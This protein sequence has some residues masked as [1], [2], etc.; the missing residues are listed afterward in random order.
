[1]GNQPVLMPCGASDR[2][3]LLRHQSHYP[4]WLLPTRHSNNIGVRSLVLSITAAAI[5]DERYRPAL[6]MDQNTL[7]LMHTWGGSPGWG[8]QVQALAERYHRVTFC[9]GIRH[10]TGAAAL[11]RFSTLPGI[12]CGL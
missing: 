8:S 3:R 12:D 10:A 6:G 7:Q 11:A 9:W 2:P 1:M 4:E 5:T